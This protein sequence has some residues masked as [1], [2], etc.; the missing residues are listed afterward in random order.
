MSGKEKGLSRRKKTCTEG[1]RNQMGFK[2][3]FRSAK[4]RGGPS[5]LGALSADRKRESSR[6][7]MGLILF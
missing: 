4:K 3:L 2:T 6:R 5:C 7:K 1:K